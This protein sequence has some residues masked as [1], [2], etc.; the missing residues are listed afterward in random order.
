LE[1][2]ESMIGYHKFPWQEK[3][4]CIAITDVMLNHLQKVKSLFS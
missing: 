3:S 1:L 2:L 4:K